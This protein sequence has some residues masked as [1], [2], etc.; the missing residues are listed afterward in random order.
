MDL[1]KEAELCSVNV[2]WYK[3]DECSTD[4]TISVSNDSNSFTDI[5]TH[6]STGNNSDFEG[7]NLSNIVSRY[8]RI[9]VTGSSEG[10]WISI[11]E[12][13]ILGT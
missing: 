1:G 8:L 10:D 5:M 4:F 2:S 9:T 6:T 13:K 12:I 7:Y 3:G 11:S